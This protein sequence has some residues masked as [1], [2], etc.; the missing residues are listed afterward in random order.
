MIDFK[1]LTIIIPSL[2][3]NIDPRWI[4]QVN[5]FN[6]KNINIIITIP[7]NLSKI[8]KFINKFDKGI[9]I[10]ISDKKGQV[11]QRQYGYKFVKTDYLMHMDDDTFIT[12]KNL[13]ILLNKNYFLKNIKIYCFIINLILEREQYQNLLLKSHIIFPLTQIKQLKVLNGYQVVYQ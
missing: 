10:I 3:S 9:L 8:N 4:E 13:K 2:L 6:Q 1:E 5:K 7:P 11:N 12:F